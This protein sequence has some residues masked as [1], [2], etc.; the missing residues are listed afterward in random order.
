MCGVLLCLHVV[1]HKFVQC[2][3]S[4]Q[5]ISDLTVNIIKAYVA[6]SRSTELD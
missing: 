4:F 1:I 2:F 3:G 5:F 6:I